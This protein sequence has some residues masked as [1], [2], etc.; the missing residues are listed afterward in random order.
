MSD[1]QLQHATISKSGEIDFPLWVKALG[2]VIGICIPI[3]FASAIWTGNV[4]WE[5]SERMTRMEAKLEAAADD[6]FRASEGA[7]LEIQIRRNAADIEEIRD[8]LGMGG[9]QTTRLNVSA[10]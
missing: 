10:P 3:A 4:M 8:R 2:W 6:R 7:L 5:M 9:R 1:T